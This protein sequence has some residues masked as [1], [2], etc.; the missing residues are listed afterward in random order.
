LAVARATTSEVEGEWES[1][2]ATDLGNRPMTITEQ[3]AE[4]LG[5]ELAAG[6]TGDFAATARELS[7]HYA[8]NV[9]G[10]DP[11][12]HEIAD[13]SGEIPA[14]GR[15]SRFLV[16]E[17]LRYL[18]LLVLLAGAVACAWLFLGV[19]DIDPEVPDTV[20]PV[21]RARRVATY[22]LAASHVLT[23]GWLVAAACY[24]RRSGVRLSRL[25]LAALCAVGVVF[26]G[27]GIAVDDFRFQAASVLALMVATVALIVGLRVFTAGQAALGEPSMGTNVWIGV[28]ATCLLLVLLGPLRTPITVST[29]SNELIFFAALCGLTM[30]IEMVLGALTMSAFENTLRASSR[31]V[32]TERR[33]A[34]ADSP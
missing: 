22:S 3:L 11:G 27:I 29:K 14:R 5:A 23:L 17:L 18:A 24:A 1:G 20:D 26:V 12:V 13:P 15:A 25:G 7:E 28:A 9:H 34:T 31:S 30:V 21:E 2:V 19:V 32:S 8:S 33:P 16:M 10:D 4:R 6:G